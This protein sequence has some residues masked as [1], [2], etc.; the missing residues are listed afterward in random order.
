MAAPAQALG[1]GGNG[2]YAPFPEPASAQQAQEYVQGLG[3]EATLAELRSGRALGLAVTEPGD[4]SR[5][6]GAEGAPGLWLLAG[7]VATL[8]AAGVLLRVRG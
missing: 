8:G 2:L 6:A 4:A 5:R 3:V 1:Q 7:L